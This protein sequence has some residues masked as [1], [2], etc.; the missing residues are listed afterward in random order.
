MGGNGVEKAA[1]ALTALRE[2][3]YDPEDDFEVEITDQQELIEF[4]KAERRRELCFEGH[5]WFDLRRWGMPEITHV[6]HTSNTE[7]HTYRLTEKDLMYTIPIPDE[8]MQENSKLVQ[9]E[10]PGKRAY[11]K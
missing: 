11:E 1:E 5:R 10:L 7:S 8:A 9:N 4:I 2:K 3:R 6:W